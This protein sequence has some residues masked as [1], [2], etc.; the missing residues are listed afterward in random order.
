MRDNLTTIAL[1]NDTIKDYKSQ[2]L[3]KQLLYTK[4]A[5]KHSILQ[6]TLARRCK[7]S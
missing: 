2:E 5:E 4:V 6:Y 3:E 1:I 7:S